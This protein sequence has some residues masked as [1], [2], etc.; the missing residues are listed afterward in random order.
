[1]RIACSEHAITGDARE[2]DSQDHRF[3]FGRRQSGLYAKGKILA[4]GESNGRTGPCVF[5]KLVRSDL[6][7]EVDVVRLS[8][9]HISRLALHP[10]RTRRVCAAYPRAC[11]SARPCSAAAIEA[12]VVCE[13]DVV[14]FCKCNHCR[15]A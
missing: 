3:G 14:F 2:L 13:L 9:I 1:M 12:L 10:P 7:D 8:L 6:D 5:G 15:I 11:A 4:F